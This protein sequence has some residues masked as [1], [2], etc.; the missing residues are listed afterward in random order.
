MCMRR[1]WTDC[2]AT[3]ITHCLNSEWLVGYACEDLAGGAASEVEGL[4]DV[5]IAAGD[6]PAAGHGQLPAAGVD[7]D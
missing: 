2:S 4:V 7:D 6:A 3:C 1:D 5:G